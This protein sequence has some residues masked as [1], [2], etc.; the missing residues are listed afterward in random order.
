MGGFERLEAGRLFVDQ[1]EEHALRDDHLVRCLGVGVGP[2]SL[3]GGRIQYAQR[4]RQSQ[5]HIDP[6]ADGDQS[7]RELHGPAFHR[8]QV[9]VPRLQSPL[10]QDGPVECVACHKGPFRRQLYQRGR[11]LVD[12]VEDPPSGRHHRADACQVVVV[13]RP[14]RVAAPLVVARRADDR[15]ARHGVATG[16][17]QAMCPIVHRDWPRLNR[18][19]PRS[20]LLDVGHAIRDQYPIDL[21]L[22]DT[23]RVLGDQQIH[24]VVAIRERFPVPALHH[25]LAVEAE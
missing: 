10:P 5:R 6:V 19:D 24:E 15:V 2:Q 11:T 25:H 1:R 21:A 9:G 22:E 16:V 14:L 13:P 3:T 8:P 4:T 7:P 18:L 12:D 23:R 17:V 20:V